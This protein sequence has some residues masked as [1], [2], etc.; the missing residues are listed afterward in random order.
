LLA[1]IENSADEISTPAELIVALRVCS[2]RYAA[3]RKYLQKGGWTLRD[4][5]LLVT[6]RLRP[7]VFHTAL[8]MFRAYAAYEHLMPGFWSDSQKT[9]NSSCPSSLLAK[10][11]LI[12]NWNYRPE[13][14][15]D[16]PIAQVEWE[17]LAAMEAEGAL[18]FIDTEM[19]AAAKAMAQ[20]EAAKTKEA[21]NGAG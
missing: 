17:R 11:D 8:E 20:E 13:E 14:V 16:L 18:N 6:M 4:V 5:F 12:R 7:I 3:A 21:A 9:H 19:I 10:R 15:L 2:R 1:E